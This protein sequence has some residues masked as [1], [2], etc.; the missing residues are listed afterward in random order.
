MRELDEPYLRNDRHARINR[1]ESEVN[2]DK[3]LYSVVAYASKHPQLFS[4]IYIVMSLKVF[5]YHVRAPHISL[6]E[7]LYRW[8]ASET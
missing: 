1:F 2:S 3:Q 8:A 6:G 7:V 4:S 5:E